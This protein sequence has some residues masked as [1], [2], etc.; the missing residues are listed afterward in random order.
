[1]GVR[2]YAIDTEKKTNMLVTAATQKIKYTF[3]TFK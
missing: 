1:M 3:N 2:L